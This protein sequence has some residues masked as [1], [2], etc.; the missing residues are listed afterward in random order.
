MKDINSRN[1]PSRRI[2]RRMRGA[3]DAALPSSTY[4]YSRLVRIRTPN[5]MGV[6]KHR[7]LDRGRDTDVLSRMLLRSPGRVD[8]VKPGY[9]IFAGPG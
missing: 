3:S 9:R 2:P 7:V 1:N 8:V 6:V 5:V 4:A